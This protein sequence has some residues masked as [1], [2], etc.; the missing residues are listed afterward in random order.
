MVKLMN[1]LLKKET[2]RKGFAPG[3]SNDNLN[4]WAVILA[5][6]DGTR[7]RSFTRSITGDERPKQFCLC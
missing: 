1:L 7:L 6:G 4:R 3:G 2:R 5:S